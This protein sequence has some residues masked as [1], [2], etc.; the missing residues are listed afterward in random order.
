MASSSLL[1]FTKKPLASRRERTR[2]ASPG[3]TA[4][5]TVM[6]SMS[7]TSRQSGQYSSESRVRPQLPPKLED[8]SGAH[9]FLERSHW[10]HTNHNFSRLGFLCA[11]GSSARNLLLV[12]L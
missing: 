9:Q 1:R 8:H 2:S 3:L 5:E 6:K 4:L 12:F 7:I 11:S 10:L